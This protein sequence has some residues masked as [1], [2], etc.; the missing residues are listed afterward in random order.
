[1]ENVLSDAGRVGVE[2]YI[3]PGVVASQFD[4][5]LK[6]SSVD[7]RLHCAAGLH[8]LYLHEHNN[9]DLR[10]LEDLCVQRRLVA[11]GEI[12]LD[13]YHGREQQQEQQLLFEQQLDIAKGAN[14]PIILHVRKAHDDILASLRRKRFTGG[15]SVHAF[16]GSI[17]QAEQYISMG[18][19]IGVGGAITHTRAKKLRAMVQQLPVN[20]IILET[21]SPD[22]LVSGQEKNGPNLPQYLPEILYKLASLKQISPEILAESTRTTTQNIFRIPLP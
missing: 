7:D 13:Y 3:I 11:L 21:D 12:G 1:L 14:L 15:G 17:Q 2:G 16:N 8:P 19:V 4:D 22:M 18:F 20:S 9:H 10:V 5:I 6:L